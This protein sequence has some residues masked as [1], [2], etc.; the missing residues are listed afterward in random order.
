MR[1]LAMV[2][3]LWLTLARRSRVE[4]S[5]DEELR[6]YVDLL[7]AEYEGAG[8]DADQAR[9]RAL[10]E[11]GG[12]EQVKE[13]TRDAWAGRGIATF[14]RE[15][16]F[17]LRGLSRAPAFCIVAV[18]ILAIGIGGATAIFTVIKGSL[19]R[20]LPAVS[21]PGALV[22]LEPTKDGTLR[23]GFSY[24]D[25]S[26]LR[27]QTRALAGLA[28]YD[29]TSLTLDDGRGERRSAWV[30]YVTGGFFSTLGVRPAAGRLI[31]PAD[32]QAANPVVVLAYDLWQERYGGDPGVIGQR[33]HVA[34]QPLTV[35]GVAS[36]RFIGA[37]LMNPM[38]LWIPFTI[39]PALVNAPGMLDDRAATFLRLVGRLAP[40]AT[41]G[42]AQEELSLL[43]ARLA[44]TYPANEARGIR[45]FPGAGMTAAERTAL[46]KLPRLLAVAVGILLLIACA[47]VANLSLVR[48]ARRRRELATRLALGA[49]RRSLFGRLLLEGAVLAAAGALLG[50]GL[51]RL[52]VH[53]PTI[54]G[55]VAGMPERVGLDVALD[56]RVL[57]VALGVS[58]FTALAVSIAPVLHVMRLPPAAV[59]KDGGAGAVRRRGF[60]QRALVVGQIAA[61]LVLLAS[62]A[63]V[64]NTFRRALATDPGFDPRG[65]TVASASLGEAK[66]DSVQVIAYRRA[67]LRR[68]VEDPRI[69]G[70]AAASVVPP[71]SWSRE[72]WFFR[73]GEEPPPG[74]RPDD[75]PAGG[76]RAH[77]DVVSP[78]FFDV[79]NLRIVAGR[80]FREDD[81]ENAAPVVVVSRRL[82]AALWPGESPLDRMLSLPAGRGTRRTPMRVVGVA[83]DVRFASIF[84][85]PPP[86]AYVPVAQHPGHSLT[87]V[88]RSRNGRG[89]PDATIRAIGD[90]TDARVP[91]HTRVV[92]EAID[93]QTRPQRVATA[94][95][96][97][98]GVVALLLAALGLYGVVAQGVLQ[99]T[100]ELAVR[101][102]LGATRRGL[103]SLVIAQGMRMA[104]IGAVV[105]VV[106]GGAALRALQSQFAGVSVGDAR[107]A[108]AAA[109]VVCAALALACYLPARRAARLDPAAALRSD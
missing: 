45:V 65:L 85:E 3:S 29:G 16:R 64:L 66:L 44:E 76:V 31:Q 20:P 71:A 73:S 104:A 34:G 80:A 100:R 97:V 36:P 108:I 75:S 50:V 68:A 91:L 57:M 81:D 79:M 33:I 94:W 105:G 62:A 35:I 14:A 23:Y 69:A 51:A 39:V 103:V 26:D 67:W 18:T 89:V 54:V 25:Y 87:F 78:G 72:R 61:S 46:G 37:M 93:A 58:A 53:S 30:S 7:A 70:V 109:V 21:D 59:L 10:I 17:T 38:E 77:L 63:I 42:E 99:R 11:T 15:I 6:A 96:G 49:S 95:I 28:G 52:L 12:I 56:P 107:G 1:V 102:A 90:A 47:N 5:L 40:G 9:R 27:E 82:A 55:T 83:D 106:A 86:V 98:F 43:A 101:S 22:S 24:L 84:D 8:M 41:V 74:A 32:E 48:A 13:A 2:R 92:T 60:G 4:R 88:V 19:L